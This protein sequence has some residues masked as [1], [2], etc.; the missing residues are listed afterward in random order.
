M[1]QIKKFKAILENRKKDMNIAYITIPFDVEKEYGTTGHVKV[2]ARFDGH[3]YRGV[4]SNVYI[5]RYIISVNK[6]IREAIG[7]DVG[8]VVKVT[9]ERDGG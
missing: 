1:E 9:L 2:K 8:D 7:K 6:D 3:P 5:G 4:I